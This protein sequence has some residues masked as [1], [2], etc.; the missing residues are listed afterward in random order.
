M[1]ERRRWP[2]RA[3]P[4]IVAQLLRLQTKKSKSNKAAV[5]S[6]EMGDTTRETPRW[7]LA[8]RSK[9]GDCCHPSGPNKRHSH[10]SRQTPWWGASHC[11]HICTR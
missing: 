11:M 8:E 1:K 3:S 4:A 5:A 6:A 2:P 7:M 9:T 10:R